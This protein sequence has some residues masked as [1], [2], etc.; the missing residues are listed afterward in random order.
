MPHDLTAATAHLDGEL[1]PLLDTQ[2]E[3]PGGNGVHFHPKIASPKAVSLQ[4]NHFALTSVLLGAR[5][6]SVA[7]DVARQL[8]QGDCSQLREVNVSPRI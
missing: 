4:A 3:P 7:F 6:S 8:R 5:V 2:P 1:T